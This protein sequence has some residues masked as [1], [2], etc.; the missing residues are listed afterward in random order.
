MNGG[1]ANYNNY[2]GN[3]NVAL[4]NGIAPQNARNI[5]NYIVGNNVNRGNIN[6]PTASANNASLRSPP[7]LQPNLYDDEQDEYIEDENENLINAN[8][9]TPQNKKSMMPLP[10]FH[11]VPTEPAFNRRRGIPVQKTLDE[12]GNNNVSKNSNNPNDNAIERAYLEGVMAALEEVES[13]LDSQDD[14]IENAKLKKL[15]MEKAEKLQAKI[16]AKAERDAEIAEFEAEQLRNAKILARRQ[17][18]LEQKAQNLTI[19]RNRLQDEEQLIATQKPRNINQKTN[20]SNIQPANYQ[21]TKKENDNKENVFASA[22]NFLKGNPQKQ[23][24]KNL[25]QQNQNQ[26]SA[27]NI[28]QNNPQQKSH[29]RQSQNLNQQ[30]GSVNRFLSPITNIISSTTKPKPLPQSAQK[31]KPKKII[32]NEEIDEPDLPTRPATFPNKVKRQVNS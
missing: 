32:N 10:R 12:N 14:E 18:E 17:A 21:Q 27:V 5:P 2:N 6:Y 13:E 11:S 16:D 7:P 8:A 15:A 23:N 29:S 22:V 1:F 20:N 24:N 30:T 4:V 9:A 25:N 31:S 28:A 26:N 19:E 3:G